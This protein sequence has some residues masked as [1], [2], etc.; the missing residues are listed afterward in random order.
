MQFQKMSF[1][2][3]FQYSTVIFAVRFAEIIF[4]RLF[5]HF[6]LRALVY[7]LP[8]L[9]ALELGKLHTR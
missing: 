9:N 2:L 5:S 4:R 7:G 6:V 1:P 8:K 3:T